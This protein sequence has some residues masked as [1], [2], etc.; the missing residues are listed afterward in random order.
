VTLFA[1]GCVELQPSH[2]TTTLIRAPTSPSVDST[3]RPNHATLLGP[4]W[5]IPPGRALELDG[6]S[7]PYEESSTSTPTTDDCRPG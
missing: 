3:A 5:A 6:R 7:L 4:Y 1:A 2:Q